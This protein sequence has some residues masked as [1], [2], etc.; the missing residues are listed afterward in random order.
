MII[1]SFDPLVIFFYRVQGGALYA[2][3]NMCHDLCQT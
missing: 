3:K 1:W 2:T